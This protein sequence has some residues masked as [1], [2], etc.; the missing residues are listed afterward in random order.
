MIVAHPDDETL[1]GGGELIQNADSYKVVVLDYGNHLVRHRE[2]I[3]AME[4]LGVTK[5]EHWDGEAFKTSAAYNESVLIPL[6][7]RVLNERDW[8]KVVTHNQSGEYGHYRH[9]GLHNVLARLCPEKLWVFGRD[10]D[11]TLSNDVKNIK[12]NILTNIYSSQKDIL[13]WFDWDHE[14]IVKY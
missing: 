11:N 14:I 3:K 12:Q 5:W 2:F 9:V 4:T 1:F 8:E 7:Q 13:K 10:S 6:I